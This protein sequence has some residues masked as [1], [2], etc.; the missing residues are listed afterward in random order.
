MCGS[1]RV[2]PTKGL[3]S[4]VVFCVEDERERDTRFKAATLRS[5]EL[6]EGVLIGSRSRTLSFHNAVAFS[7]IG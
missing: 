7:V 6:W 4:F 3:V 2:R 5:A 1:G